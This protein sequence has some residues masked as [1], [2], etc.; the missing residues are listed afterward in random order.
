MGSS[1]V[2]AQGLLGI[3]RDF[4][5]IG[6][7]Q[8]LRELNLE[9]LTGRP[10]ADVFVAMLEFICPPGGAVDEGIA[11]QAMIE[12]IGDMAEAGIGSFD[13]M[14]GD[15][16]QEMFLD[17]IIHSIEGRVMA[18]IGMKGIS[19]PDDVTAVE[20]IQEQLH[21]FV[22]GATRGQLTDR[23]DGLTSLSDHDIET[24]VDR[25]YETA[26]DLIAAAG[27]AAQ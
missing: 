21:D 26:F 16:L 1:R 10:A 3:V 4:Q 23:L 17:F 27:E 9:R 11:R 24:T 6:P 25:I 14:T 22:S 19:L 5:R 12:T 20:H 2:A 8:V 13:S 18:D 7:Q 15:Q